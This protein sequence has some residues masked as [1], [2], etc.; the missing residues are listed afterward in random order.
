MV[1]V[2]KYAVGTPCWVELATT[3]VAAAKDFYASLFGWQYDE[4]PLPDGGVYVIPHLRDRGVGG[5]YQ[6]RADQKGMPPSW[7]V[8]VSV[9][10]VDDT[11]SRVTALDGALTGAPV[12]VGD[13][14]RMAVLQDPTGATVALW[15]A[16]K[17]I[18]AR[19]VAETGAF[20]WAEL[21]TR[22]PNRAADFY[23][24][25]FGWEPEDHHGT[26]TEFKAGDRV[27]AGM[28]EIDQ[29]FP[30][31]VPPHWLT[32]FGVADCDAAAALVDANGG[33]VDRAP[34]DI[35]DVG[36]IAVVHDPQGAH[37]AV[38]VGS[39]GGGQA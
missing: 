29:R 2:D 9:N 17:S 10:D 20:S 16:N 1:D 15:Q 21:A 24:G 23:C 33:G 36:R 28:L 25:L 19:V 38:W 30:P 14:G 6:Q 39:A 37:F 11:A 4:G 7:L 34:F 35:P 27:V 22:D 5:I 31:G 32:Y 3:D 18:G 13:S 12:D 26:Y 8:Y